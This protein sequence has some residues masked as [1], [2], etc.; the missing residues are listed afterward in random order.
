M[1]GMVGAVV[2]GSLLALSAPGA[3]EAQTRGYLGIGGGV[4]IP[5]GDFADGVKT[6]WLGQVVGGVTLSNGI[7]G[8]RVDGTY[9]QN[10]AKGTGDG[11][12]KLIG[13]LG[14]VVVSPKMAGKAKPYVLAGAGM[15]NAKISAGTVSESDTKFAWNAGAG[16]AFAAGKVGIYLEARFLSVKTEGS[17]SNM[18]PITAGVRIGGN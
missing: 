13:A 11:K 1:K 4:N 5:M 17:S 8:F 7:L 2:L 9:G 14:D 16:V 15:M 12:F 18:I 6:G 10:N 3:A